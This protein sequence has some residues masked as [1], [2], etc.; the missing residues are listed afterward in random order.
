METR[1]RRVIEA[2]GQSSTELRGITRA[3]LLVA[4]GVKE[5]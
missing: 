2:E 3:K 5:S 4:G 1:E